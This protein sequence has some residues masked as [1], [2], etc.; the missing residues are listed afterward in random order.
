MDQTPR[1]LRQ[2]DQAR[3][4]GCSRWTVRRIAERDPTYPPQREISPG[5]V[6]VLAHELDAWLRSRPVINRSRRCGRLAADA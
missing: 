4:L 3:A 6:G 1:L 5:V 2:A